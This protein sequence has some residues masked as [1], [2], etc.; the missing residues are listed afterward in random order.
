MTNQNHP[1]SIR[2]S[3]SAKAILDSTAKRLRRSRSYV[4]EDMLKRQLAVS[5]DLQG[6]SNRSQAIERLKAWRER[7]EAATSGR[8][9][10]DIDAMI[11]ELRGDD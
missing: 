2:L 7:A 10:K 5:E 6:T 4:V 1:V 8:D 11:R 3:Q 9:P